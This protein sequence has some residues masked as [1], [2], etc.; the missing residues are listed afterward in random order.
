MNRKLVVLA[1]ISL[2][3]L[4]GCKPNQP[5]QA[6]NLEN[7]K[8][9]TVTV[10]DLSGWSFWGMGKAFDAGNGQFCLMEND[11]SLGVTLISPDSYQGDV[12]VRYKTLALTASTVLVAMHSASDKGAGGTLTIPQ[13]HNG[14]MGLW[15]NEKDNYFYAFRN[16][17]HNATPFIRKYP[18]MGNEPIGSYPENIMLPGIYYDIELGRI[19]DT[20]WLSINDAKIIETADNEMF[21]GG[22][23][24][25]RVRGSAGLKAACLIKD[26][27]IYSVQ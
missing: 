1:M 16:A 8:K 10:Q 11:S 13:G 3:V 9:Q 14:N 12:I 17:P 20:L 23:I 18:V 5:E 26:L 24:A 25:F 2:T 7:Y 27:E 15:I 19:G 21:P 4:A 6:K 22:H